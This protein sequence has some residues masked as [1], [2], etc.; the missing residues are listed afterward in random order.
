MLLT[1]FI[2]SCPVFKQNRILTLKF[3]HKLTVICYS[4]VVSWL[5]FYEAVERLSALG[6]SV[7]VDLWREE[8]EAEI[9]EKKA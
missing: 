2:Q 7:K 1:V 5:C 6:L 4:A 9:V 3:P 8:A